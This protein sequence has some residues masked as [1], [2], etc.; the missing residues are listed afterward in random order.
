MMDFL[1]S[2]GNWFGN[3]LSSVGTGLKNTFG[4]VSNFMDDVGDNPIVTSSFGLANTA[5]T[6]HSAEKIA[7]INAEA[8]ENK[9]RIYGANTEG[10][11]KV[12]IVGG[13]ILAGLMILKK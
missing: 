4:S 11:V 12:A 6:A 13:L 9:A 10:I 5:L 7:K 1:G 3:T 8:S 2:I